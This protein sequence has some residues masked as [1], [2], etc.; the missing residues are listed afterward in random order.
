MTTLS[1][2]LAY[3]M[4]RRDRVP[5]FDIRTEVDSRASLPAIL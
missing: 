3:P 5:K 1:E 4:H 2:L